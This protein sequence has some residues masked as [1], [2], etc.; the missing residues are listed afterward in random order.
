M[1]H[2]R[3]IKIHA[4]DWPK[5]SLTQYVINS[6]FRKVPF[7]STSVAFMVECTKIAYY[8]VVHFELSKVS[9]YREIVNYCHFPKGTF[10]H[11]KHHR[12]IYGV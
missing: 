5:K 11:S 7:N 12:L 3:M 10:R 4:F 2:L 8:Y 6:R 9:Q 1:K